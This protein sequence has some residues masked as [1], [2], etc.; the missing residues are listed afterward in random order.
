MDV[1]FFTALPSKNEFT[2][3]DS[4]KPNPRPL[5]QEWPNDERKTYPKIIKEN[6]KF[7]IWYAYDQIFRQPVVKTRI[8][9]RNPSRMKNVV[10]SLSLSYLISTLNAMLGNTLSDAMDS[11]YS[12]NVDSDSKGVTMSFSVSCLLKIT[13]I[14]F[15]I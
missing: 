13:S 4:F 11:G 2:L 3:D 15:F 12:G 9:F 6:S 7:R 8:V 14:K 10:Q 5:A 1:S